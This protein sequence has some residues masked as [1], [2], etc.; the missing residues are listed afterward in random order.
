MLERNSK[1]RSSGRFPSDLLIF[2]FTPLLLSGCSTH[3]CDASTQSEGPDAGTV[4]QYDGTWTW[5]TSSILSGWITFNGQETIN[6]TLPSDFPPLGTP[7]MTLVPYVSTDPD[8]VDAGQFVVAGGQPAEMQ[9]TG[10]RSF[11]LLN[12]TCA[13]YYLRVV[14]TVTVPPPVDAGGDAPHD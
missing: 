4:T 12:A 1:I 3:Q 14:A 11:S 5:Q 13:L 9:I 10:A 8:Q 6:F 7:G 2:L